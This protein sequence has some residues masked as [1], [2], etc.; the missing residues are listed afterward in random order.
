MRDKVACRDRSCDMASRC[1]L[2]PTAARRLP[3]FGHASLLAAGARTTRHRLCVL[4][5]QIVDSG[6]SLWPPLRQARCLGLW[7]H[8]DSQAGAAPRAVPA[9]PLRHAVAPCSV[10]LAQ[11]VDSLPLLNAL[12]VPPQ[13]G[14][15]FY[16][17]PHVCP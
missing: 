16:C 13:N 14:L 17:L 9:S 2:G 12:V 1:E 15:L 6:A 4:R 11:T 3:S 5:S 10:Y 7:C 8:S